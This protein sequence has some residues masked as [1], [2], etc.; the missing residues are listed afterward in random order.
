MENVSNN[1]SQKESLFYALFFSSEQG[2]Q[3]AVDLYEA[4]SGNRVKNARKINIEQSSSNQL[5]DFLFYRFDDRIVCITEQQ[6]ISSDLTVRMFMSL[7]RAYDQLTINDPRTRYGTKLY[8][9]PSPEF[10]VLYN[11][12]SELTTRELQ[13]SDMFIESSDSLQLKAEVVNIHTGA[14][15][16][17]GLDKCKILYEYSTVIEKAKEMG[18]ENAVL[19]CIEN[20]I[21][22]DYLQKHKTDIN[23]M[24][25]YTVK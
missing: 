6:T 22:A 5:S 13:L 20:D 21:L 19:Y 23:S 15:K 3:N 9:I 17:S 1:N 2:T 10:Y 16:K 25:S 14:L 18:A 24:L 7:G 12:D 8:K 11:E 4:I